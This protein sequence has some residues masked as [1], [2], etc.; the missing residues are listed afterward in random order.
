MMIGSSVWQI[1]INSNIPVTLITISVIILILSLR[2]QLIILMYSMTW[3]KIFPLAAHSKY[4][5]KNGKVTNLDKLIR[6]IRRARVLNKWLGP[7][8][9]HIIV[10]LMSRLSKFKRLKR[11]SSISQWR[12]NWR[13]TIDISS[14][15]TDILHL[16]FVC[17]SEQ[18]I[19]Q[20]NKR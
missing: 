10:N 8:K 5:R 13:S 14:R 3:E 4:N 15:S 11:S 1:V 6:L 16:T 17:I 20:I 19:S 9:I 18:L 2:C 12:K 7:F